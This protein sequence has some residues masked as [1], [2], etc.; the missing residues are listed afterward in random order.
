MSSRSRRKKQQD[1][2]R[3][4]Q[5]IDEEDKNKIRETENFDL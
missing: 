4:K 1:L 2:D 5:A 3:A